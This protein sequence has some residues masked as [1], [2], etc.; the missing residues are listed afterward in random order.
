MVRFSARERYI[1]RLQI[2]KTDSGVHPFDRCKKLFLLRA[3]CLENEADCFP[4]CSAIVENQLR[5]T[6]TSNHAFSSY[7]EIAFP[8][9]VYI[10]RK[11]SPAISFGFI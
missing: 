8:L 1:S 5:Y 2:A 9:V 7:T 4:P 11:K 6:S 10:K 3:K